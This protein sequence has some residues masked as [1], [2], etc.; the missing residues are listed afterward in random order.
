MGQ[1]LTLIKSMRYY[2]ALYLLNN[3][4]SIAFCE[5]ITPILKTLMMIGIVVSS[6][7]LISNRTQIPLPILVIVFSSRAVSLEALVF[8][9]RVTSFLYESASE[10][11]N[12]LLSTILIF[13]HA[14]TRNY[15]RKKLRGCPIVKFRIGNLYF[16]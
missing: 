1:H 15:Y 9:A 14:K 10:L 12:T 3:L 6:F 13:R 5:I 7:T 4:T 8:A 2:K 11:H 16:M